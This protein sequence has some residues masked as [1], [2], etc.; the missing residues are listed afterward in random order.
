M[1]T[2]FGNTNIQQLRSEVAWDPTN[3]DTVVERYRGL[4]DDIRGLI[5]LFR[6]E[7][8]KY[9]I[10][11]DGTGPWSTLELRA[12]DAL[13][14]QEPTATELT[15][16]WEMDGNELQKD[17][18]TFSGMG[19]TV[20]ERAA[21]AARIEFEFKQIQANVFTV[22]ESVA[23]LTATY[24]AT[25]AHLL[26]LK[27]LK[28]ESYEISQFVLRRNTILPVKYDGKWSITNV[29]KQWTTAQLQAEFSIP[30]T[31]KFNLPEGAWLKRVPSIRQ[32]KDGRFLAV[33]LW[34]HGDAIDTVLYPVRT[35]EVTP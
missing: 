12:A 30:E 22:A 15:T 23:S 19:D 13:D 2:L 8:F 35:P 33:D 10:I 17:L 24:N 34:F 9:R 5:P 18:L 11:P 32:Q 3:G 25:V 21:A 20:A 14:G 26:R 31:I 27:L 16:T 6:A 28:V 7:G 4:D 29:M 1:R